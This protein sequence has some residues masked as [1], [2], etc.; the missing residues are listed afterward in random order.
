[1]LLR[2]ERYL[3]REE[4]ASEEWLRPSSPCAG[5]GTQA[6]GRD[7]Q[8]WRMRDLVSPFFSIDLFSLLAL[9]SCPRSSEAGGHLS[10]PALLFSFRCSSAKRKKA[11]IVLEARPWCSAGKGVYGWRQAPHRLLHP[12]YYLSA[13]VSISTSFA[14]LY[15]HPATSSTL[16]PDNTVSCRIQL[17]SRDAQQPETGT[18]YPAITPLHVAALLTGLRTSRHAAPDVPG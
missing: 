18:T 12:C 14:A 10:F 3:G 5:P 1:M 6:R 17:R 2:A 4:A 15:I 13:H 7:R 9:F 8:C 16:N 11:T